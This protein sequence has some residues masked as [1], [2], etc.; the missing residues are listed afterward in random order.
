MTRSWLA[1]FG[2]AVVGT[3]ARAAP[4]QV[5]WDAPPGCDATRFEAQLQELLADSSHEIQVSVSVTRTPVGWAVETRFDAGPERHGVRRFEAP[6]CETVSE[7]A[8]L[9]IALAIDPAALERRHGQAPAP[10][11]APQPAPEPAVPTPAEPPAPLAPAPKV[12]ASAPLVSPKPI[13]LGGSAGVLGFVDGLALPGVGGGFAGLTAL[14]VAAF[15]VE[16]GGGYRFATTDASG[17][18]PAV[19][20][21]FWAWSLSAHGLWSP[22]VGPLELPVGLGFEVGQTIGRADGF[23]GSR[24]AREPWLAPLALTGIAWPIRPR[25]AL[26]A[27]AELA[28]PLSRPRFV[29]DGLEPIHHG[30]PVRIRGFLGVEGRFP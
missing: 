2:L 5:Q 6:A 7:A 13:G 27:R 29:V 16:V 19:R 14:R 30:G 28:I 24:V 25:L 4:P 23:E 10:A 9:A 12:R 17:I 18:D 3:S 22:A 11:P 15:R 20:V 1:A 26:L 21:R 8:A